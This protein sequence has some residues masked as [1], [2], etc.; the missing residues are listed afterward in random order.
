[1]KSELKTVLPCQ[2]EYRQ[3][4]YESKYVLHIHI[5]HRGSEVNMYYI[6]CILYILQYGSGVKS[7][8]VA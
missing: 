6:Q 4:M 3:I 7:E 1:M 2:L 8:H 5:L